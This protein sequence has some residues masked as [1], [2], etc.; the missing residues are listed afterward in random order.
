MYTHEQIWAAIDRL[1]ESHGYSTSGLAKNAGLDPTTFN[2]SKRLGPDGKQRW[3]STESISKILAVTETKMSEF[4]ALMDSSKAGIPFKI[5]MAGCDGDSNG[6]LFK[7]IQSAPNDVWTY[8]P[9]PFPNEGTRDDLFALKLNDNFLEPLYRK[10]D[11]LVV[12]KANKLKQGDR[13][14]ILTKDNHMYVQE[15]FR[16]S[17]AGFHFHSLNPEADDQLLKSNEIHWIA[18]IV[19]VSQ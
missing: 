16:M 13:V 5:P 10:N 1:A 7:D 8:F 19:W 2:R 11:V 12:E 18:K 17:D 14:I 4:V 6:N 9:F 3:P 15:V